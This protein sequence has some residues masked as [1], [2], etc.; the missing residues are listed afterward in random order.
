MNKSVVI[1]IVIGV[2]VASAGA[3]IANYAVNSKSQDSAGA[4]AE[5]DSGWVA[6]L[7]PFTEEKPAYAEVL[8]VTP[9]VE[10]EN[11][12]REVCDQV[13]VTE[14][15]PVKDQNQ[16]TGTVAGALIGGVL[17][18]QVGD[19]RAKKVATV[20]GA[21]AGG[22]TGKKVQENMQDSK[23]V[24]HVENR[25]ETVY[26]TREINRGYDV[27]YKLGDR[28]GTVHM[29]RDPGDRIPVENGELQIH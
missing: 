4:E 10:T 16:I 25:C 20:A 11:I 18:S 21:V 12:P 1:G 24:T 7:L 15:A 19:G 9:V 5:S 23:T 17:G 14:K 28:E 8:R 3:V 2:V 27:A 26:D 22:Y 13:Q 6:D 29:D